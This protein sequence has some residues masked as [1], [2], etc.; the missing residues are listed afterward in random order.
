MWIR[1]I[2]KCI[3]LQTVCRGFAV[4]TNFV[5]WFPSRNM[6]SAQYMKC[7]CCSAA[8]DVSQGQT[9]HAGNIWQQLDICRRERRK[10]KQ[11]CVLSGEFDNPHSYTGQVPSNCVCEVQLAVKDEQN[12]DFA[13]SL[14]IGV[15][16]DYLVSAVRCSWVPI[17][18]HHYTNWT[19][20]HPL[21]S[22]VASN[23]I[24]VI[25]RWTSYW[26]CLFLSNSNWCAIC[27][28]P[29][30]GAQTSRAPSS[31][32]CQS[33]RKQTLTKN[34]RGGGSA[35]RLTLLSKAIHQVTSSGLTIFQSQFLIL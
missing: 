12:R 1:W 3:L 15:R 2:H 23:R 26:N 32:Q 16:Q 7:I 30:T 9:Q 29:V 14:G 27:M 11:Q 13:S 6:K 34:T 10:Q 35:N 19:F 17:R 18:T 31:L 5:M 22:S 25:H 4:K 24:A 33:L 20:C 28:E 21:V 8:Q